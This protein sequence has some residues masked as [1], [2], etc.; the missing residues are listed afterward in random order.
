MSVWDR[1]FR[2][3]GGSE[4]YLPSFPSSGAGGCENS[5]GEGGQWGSHGCGWEQDEKLEGR[6]T[7]SILSA[8]SGIR[9][10]I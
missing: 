2:S 6:G 4:T 3:A 7:V 9:L 1:G 5:R 8:S 10:L